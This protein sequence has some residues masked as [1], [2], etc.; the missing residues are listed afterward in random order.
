[1]GHVES[2]DETVRMGVLNVHDAFLQASLVKKYME[3]S[4][5]VADPMEFFVS[6]RGRFERLWVALLYVL[7]EAWCSDQMVRV[8]EFCRSIISLDELDSL[9]E[10][11][12]KEGL[13]S[14]MRETRHYV[15]HRDRRK[16]WDDGRTGPVGSLDYNSKL[17][18]AFSRVLLATIRAV[19]RPD[20]GP[21][22][23]PMQP[24][25]SAGG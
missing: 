25:G 22:N 12:Q 7:V 18:D 4:S 16:Y 19:P 13:L 14:K 15:C 6:D 8:R 1:M 5:V 9:L 3:N 23:P 2:M 10:R 17:H 20:G 11:G 21:S 24:P